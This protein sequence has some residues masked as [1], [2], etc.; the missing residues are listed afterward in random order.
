MG[1][2]GDALAIGVYAPAV[3]DR[4]N[5]AVVRYL[6]RLVGVPKSSIAIVRGKTARVK[7]ISF[8]SLTAEDLAARLREA[9]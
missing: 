6:A 4:A 3:E 9:L 2:R 8:C 1:V 5:K 7:T